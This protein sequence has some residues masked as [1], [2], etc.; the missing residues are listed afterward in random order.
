[1][2]LLA[3]LCEL[4]GNNE[5]GR[6]IKRRATQGSVLGPLL[7]N[8][9]FDDILRIELPKKNAACIA[10]ADDLALLIRGSNGDQFRNAANCTLQRITNWLK[11]KRLQIAI[12]RTEL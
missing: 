6:K 4:D 3:K 5:D 7:W 8:L 10:Y 2:N 12:D 9:F 11:E 1:M